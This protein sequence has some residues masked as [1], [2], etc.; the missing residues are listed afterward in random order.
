MTIVSFF[1]RKKKKNRTV[2]DI[3][4]EKFE[5]AALEVGV[6]KQVVSNHVL[7]LGTQMRLSQC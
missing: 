2:S 1:G 3:A 6:T 5:K 4:F 7:I